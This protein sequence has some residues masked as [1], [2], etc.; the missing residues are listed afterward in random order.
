MYIIREVVQ[1]KPG[2]VKQLLERFRTM[3]VVMREMDQEPPRLLTDV[4]GGPF[5]TLVAELTVEKI[6]DFFAVEQRLMTNEVLRKTMADY[7]EFVDSGRREIF[8][9]ES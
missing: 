2:K 1:C 5:W 3:S 4:T 9:L 7:H 6:D 8:R